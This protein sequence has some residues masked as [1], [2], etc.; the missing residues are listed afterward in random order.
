MVSY[1]GDMSPHPVSMDPVTAS[2]NPV[3][4]DVSKYQHV[5][6]VKNPGSKSDQESEGQ[7]S[8]AHH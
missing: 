5:S 1:A 4:S 6:H 7:P 3:V 2:Q 8:Q